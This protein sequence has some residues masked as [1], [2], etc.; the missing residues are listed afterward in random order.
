MSSSP[1][2]LLHPFL[3][4]LFS[5]KLVWYPGTEANYF[6]DAWKLASSPAES[7]GKMSGLIK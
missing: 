5:L 2:F 7:S 4:A 6:L 3:G 1:A